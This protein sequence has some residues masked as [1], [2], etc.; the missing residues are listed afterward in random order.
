MLAP[1]VL[2]KNCLKKTSAAVVGRS[3][4]GL[5]IM[6]ASLDGSCSLQELVASTSLLLPLASSVGVDR[7]GETP[8]ATTAFTSDPKILKVLLLVEIT[9]G[10]V[11]KSELL[12]RYVE[13]HTHPSTLSKY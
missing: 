13:P 12:T 3:Y 4:L 9:M 6:T 7:V 5:V 2:L 8:D 10:A 1:Y 11:K